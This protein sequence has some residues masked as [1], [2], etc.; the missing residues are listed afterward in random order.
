[1]GLV[2]D[3]HSEELFYTNNYLLWDNNKILGYD[4]G[5][6]INSELRVKKIIDWDTDLIFAFGHPLLSYGDQQYSISIY[7]YSNHQER[8]AA[9]CYGSYGRALN[10]WYD[11]HYYCNK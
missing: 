11:M 8:I 5:I 1:M 4:R 3:S 6:E 7:D 2:N 10:S 9:I